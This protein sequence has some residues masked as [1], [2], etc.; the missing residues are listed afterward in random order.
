M[1][2]KEM[3]QERF[4]EVSTIKSQIN[5]LLKKFRM[6]RTKDIVKCIKKLEMESLFIH[7]KTKPSKQSQS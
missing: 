7:D 6:N 4:V 3:A 2:V 5:S 1:K